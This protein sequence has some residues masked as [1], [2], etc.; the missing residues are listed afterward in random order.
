VDSLNLYLVRH[1]ETIWNAQA[2][3]QGHT[4]VA[5]SE[6]GLRQSALVADRFRDMPVTCVYSSDLRRAMQT[7]E[8]I[9]EA[10]AAPLHSRPALREAAFGEWEGLTRDELE[11]TGEKGWAAFKADPIVFRPPGGE[12]IAEMIERV[13]ADFDEI[14]RG[15]VTGNIVVV[16]S[17]GPIKGIAWRLLQGTSQTIHRLRTDNTAVSLVQRSPEGAYTL[18]FWNDTHH[19]GP[20]GATAVVTDALLRGKR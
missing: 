17:G 15:H 20:D 18:T 3:L 1:G 5:L 11:A 12:A 16:T 10:T 9:A 13:W 8:A 19:L 6:D 4:D 7:A 14:A 2:R